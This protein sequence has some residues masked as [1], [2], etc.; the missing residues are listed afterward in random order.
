MLPFYR[1]SFIGKNQVFAGAAD[2]MSIRPTESTLESGENSPGLDIQ[3][4]PNEL[5]SEIVVYSEYPGHDDE[6]RDFRVYGSDI[7]ARYAP[8]GAE[9]PHLVSVENRLHFV[10]SSE[11]DVVSKESGL[12]VLKEAIQ[13]YIDDYDKLPI[14]YNTEQGTLTFML[15]GAPQRN[16]IHH[17]A[18]AN[19]HR[20]IEAFQPLIEGA[21]NYMQTGDKSYVVTDPSF[22]S[23]PRLV[24]LDLFK[25]DGA[26]VL[27]VNSDR[28][29][30]DLKNVLEQLQI[31]T[32]DEVFVGDELDNLMKRLE[33]QGAS[34]EGYSREEAQARILSMLFENLNDWDSIFSGYSSAGC[35]IPVPDSSDSYITCVPSLFTGANSFDNGN[36]YYGDFDVL[37]ED[38]L[39]TEDSAMVLG[40]MCT[41]EG[42]PMA[43]VVFEL[44]GYITPVYHF[45]IGANHQDIVKAVRE[46]SGVWNATIS[47]RFQYDLNVRALP[48][49]ARIRWSGLDMP[50]IASKVECRGISLGAAD[51]DET[52]MTNKSPEAIK[53]GTDVMNFLTD[54]AR[55]MNIHS[56]LVLTK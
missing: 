18:V 9:A 2:L 55:F 6:K 26:F 40:A 17:G 30:P 52:N 3:V 33:F 53:A 32:M 21:A 29:G 5:L 51:F 8:W 16:K 45:V 37:S 49:T 43:G 14:I 15:A 28:L 20:D 10:L 22:L 27:N 12:D 47:P 56:G 23:P 31:Q 4:F 13:S 1:M 50:I 7:L 11:F 36:R 39:T 19:T 46:R 25:H 48:E 44:Q 24:S 34:F 42:V 38:S 41:S 35:K 54:N